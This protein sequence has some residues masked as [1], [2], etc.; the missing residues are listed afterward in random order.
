MSFKA[1]AWLS[2][3]VPSQG[4]LSLSCAALRAQDLDGFLS[5]L[6]KAEVCCAADGGL[7]SLQMSGEKAYSW[8]SSYS[9][10]SRAP[11]PVPINT[12]SCSVPQTSLLGSYDIL[13]LVSEP[14]QIALFEECF[15]SHT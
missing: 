8:P 10:A 5:R 14:T 9:A 13:V 15:R 2:A 12:Q 6:W 3:S 4:L 11:V 1:A 7:H